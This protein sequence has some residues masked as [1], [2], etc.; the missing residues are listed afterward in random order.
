QQQ[1]CCHEIGFAHEEIFVLVE[2]LEPFPIS[3]RILRVV[4][5]KQSVDVFARQTPRQQTGDEVAGERTKIET[6]TV[7]RIDKTGRVTNRSPWDDWWPIPGWC[8]RRSPSPEI[9]RAI[10]SYPILS[11]P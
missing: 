9:F 5:I 4:V 3:Y 2:G 11:Y 8:G 1:R 10:H 6:R 7:E